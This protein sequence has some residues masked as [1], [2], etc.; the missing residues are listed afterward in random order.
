MDK[1]SEGERLVALETKMD[2]VLGYQEA[3]AKE[4]KQLNEKLGKLL[5]MYALKDE[6]KDGFELLESRI[7]RVKA[8]HV[9]H[10]WLVGGLSAVFSSIVTLLVTYFFT[11][12]GGL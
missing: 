12:S 11:T 8:K 2:M 9:L 10:V 6:V 7:E 3:Q 5:P 4:A 1:L